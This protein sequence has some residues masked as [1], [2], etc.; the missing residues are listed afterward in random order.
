M[1]NEGD[2]KN[3]DN[4]K[5]LIKN[6]I[7]QLNKSH[8]HNKELSLD[9]YINLSDYIWPGNIKQLK[10]FITRVYNITTS[11][12]IDNKIVLTEL[13]NEF[14]YDEQNY[15]DNWKFNFRNLFYNF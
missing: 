3:K 4:I 15:I 12:L 1:I 5:Q 7:F 14:S 13:S 11:N 6:L 2:I 10:N 9:S 8:N